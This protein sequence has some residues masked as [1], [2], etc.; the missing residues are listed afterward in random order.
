VVKGFSKG[1]GKAIATEF[2][3]NGYK[4]ILNSRQESE[5]SEAANDLTKSLKGREER[6]TSLVGDIFQP[7]VCISLLDHAIRSFGKIDVFVNNT[8]IGGA[9]KRL[10]GLT[11]AEWDYVIDVNLRGAFL[12][13]R[14][15]LKRMTSRSKINSTSNAYSIIDISSVHE[16]IPQP[17]STPYSASKG[18]MQMLTKTVPLE[19]AD[20]PIRGNEIAPRAIATDMN[21]DILEDE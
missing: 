7:N 6:V 16:S 4:A 8:G 18:D 19:V 13:T 21:S 2:A 9:Q 20:R 3:N 11:M 17:Q 1:I 14:E 12:G 15:A 5:L 10:D